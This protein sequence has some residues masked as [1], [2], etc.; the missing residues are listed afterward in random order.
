MP[1]TALH[2]IE[3]GKGEPLIF[4]HGS[5]SDYRT[6]EK[7]LP[8]FAGHFRTLVYSRR[9]HWPNPVI[10]ENEDYSMMQHIDD[11]KGLIL[12]KAPVGV[13]LAGHSYGAFICLK[14]AME[15]PG[16]VRTLTL[17]EPPV[18]TI[19]VSNSPKPG[20]LLKLLPLKPRLAIEI[21]KF[22]LEGVAP[23]K[24]AFEKGLPEKA[25][26]I[27]GNATLGKSAF[28]RLSPSRMEQARSNLFKMELMGSGFPQLDKEQIKNIRV[29]VMLISGDRSPLMFRLLLRELT[30][31]I[32]GADLK[33]ISNASHIMHEDNS[34]Q[35]NKVLMSFLKDH[36][37]PRSS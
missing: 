11:L 15:H 14:L 31:L 29:P 2:T 34:S 4:V 6:W 37:D 36:L 19:F 20:E 5:A 12:Q 10:L 30:K 9:Y 25:L 33:I 8:Y 21:I 27:F 13:H 22:G 28:Q 35:Y 26:E 16:L 24:K 17:A 23:A 3:E 7:Q 32:S 1:P 18:I